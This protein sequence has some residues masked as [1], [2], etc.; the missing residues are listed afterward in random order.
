MF[1]VSEEAKRQSKR[2]RNCEHATSA[3]MQSVSQIRS[4]CNITNLNMQWNY[5]IKAHPKRHFRL[6]KFSIISSYTF[7]S[8]NFHTSFHRPSMFLWRW[9]ILGHTHAALCVQPAGTEQ[10]PGAAPRCPQQ[11][12]VQQQQ[13]AAQTS[14]TPLAAPRPGL[15]QQQQRF[16]VAALPR[17]RRWDGTRCTKVWL[18]TDNG[19]RR[20]PTPR[21]RTHWISHPSS[22]RIQRECTIPRHILSSSLHEVCIYYFLHTAPIQHEQMGHVGGS[23]KLLHITEGSQTSC[24]CPQILNIKVHGIIF[25]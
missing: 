24:A 5:K 10:L 22:S 1:Y 9:L 18:H 15:P 4:D 21:E 17:L 11:R 6:K 19:L 16:G 7:V 23:K 3:Q 20:F 12:P 14:A 25:L 13:R 2:I 8:I